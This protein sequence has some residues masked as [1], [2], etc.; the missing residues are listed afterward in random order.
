[1]SDSGVA[2]CF[3][4]KSG[5]VHWS[6]RLGGG[7]SASPVFADGRIYFQNEEGLGYVLKAGKTYE[8]L[9]KNDLG[10]RTLASPAVAD[11]TI[12]LRSKSHL[13]RIGD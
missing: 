2:S 7:F 1:M 12:F 11:N 10:D 3:D 5:S 13:W 9:A 6:E 8:L 4:A